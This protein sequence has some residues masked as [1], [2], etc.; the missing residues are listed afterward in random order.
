[1]RISQRVNNIK[2]LQL[3]VGFLLLVFSVVFGAS[4][5]HAIA[6]GGLGIYPNESEVNEEDPLS[7]AWFIY[8]LEPGEVKEGKVDV[9]NSFNEPVEVLVYPVDA[10][11][12][13]DGAFAPEPLDREKVGVGLWTTLVESSVFLAPGETKAIN[14]TIEVPENAEVGDHMG[15]IIIQ[16]KEP[17]AEIEGSGLRIATRVGVRMYITLPGERLVELEFKE[18]TW[19]VVEEKITF[20]LTLVN[21]GNVRIRPRGAIEIINLF[22]RMVETIP[23]P[24]RE[25]FPRDTITLPVAWKDAP[26]FGMFT[27][28]ASLTYDADRTLTRSVRV[29]M[30]PSRR[31]FLGVGLAFGMFIISLAGIFRVVRGRKRRERDEY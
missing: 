23:I 10:V 7:K 24:E 4:Y 25:V 31:M 12:T 3:F 5:A 29:W 11:T 15:A 13:V 17:L 27:A 2:T 6:Y 8:T 21:N 26:S 22:G 19:E 30:F 1:M 14:F 16:K 28:R 9:T 18:L 20:A